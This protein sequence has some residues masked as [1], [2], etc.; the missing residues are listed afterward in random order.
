MRIN[1]LGY[2]YEQLKEFRLIILVIMSFL[3]FQVQS[4]YSQDDNNYL[5]R[6]AFLSNI[7]TIRN[8]QKLFEIELVNINGE[9][10]NI[11]EIKSDY[12]LIYIWST[13]CRPC[14]QTLNESAAIVK[15][16]ENIEFV[17]ISIDED[18]S[19]WEKLLNRKGYKGIHLHTNESKKPPISYLIY[20]VEMENGRMISYQGG[21][22][23]VLL[24]DRKKNI[25]ENNVPQYSTEAIVKFLR[26]NTK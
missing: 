24:L 8:G 17:F 23:T 6:I 9:L 2:N 26:D 19:R 4:L 21:V 5:E 22:P 7:D 15:E 14:L 13:Y 20:R 11:D 10:V 25:V 1:K 3:F 18:K 16:F 12:T